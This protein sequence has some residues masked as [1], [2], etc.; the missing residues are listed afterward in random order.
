VTFTGDPANPEVVVTAGWTAP[1]GTRVYAEFAGPLKT[2]TVT[3]RSEP[4]H[5]KSEILALILFGSPTGSAQTYTAG[6]PLGAGAAGVAGLGAQV[7][8]RGLNRAIDQL[9][10]L[11]V[12]TR[13]NTTDVVNPRP[14]VAVRL[15]RDIS[16]AVSHVLGV[17]PPGTNPDRNF[18]TF[19]WRFRRS[20]SLQTTI[21]DQGS[22]VLDLIWQYRY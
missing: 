6:A 12:T 21:G 10:G 11:D 2:G 14:E 9:T 17:P 4:A 18:A 16:I 15:A 3:L 22:T 19:D 13:I 1:E 20:W 5:S 8:T 7:A